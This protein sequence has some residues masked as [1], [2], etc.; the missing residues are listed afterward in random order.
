MVVLV[1]ELGN[2]DTQCSQVSDILL[3][4]S[5]LQ[6]ISNSVSASSILHPSLFLRLRSVIVSEKATGGWKEVF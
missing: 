1:D 5:V 4:C 3:P 2:T 6:L